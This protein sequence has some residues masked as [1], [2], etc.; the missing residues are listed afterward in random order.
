M[1]TI[2]PQLKTD[3]AG[4][5]ILMKAIAKKLDLSY[6]SLTRKLANKR[7]FNIDEV[8]KICQVL[9]IDYNYF[10]ENYIQNG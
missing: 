10:F 3:L 1:V 8:I 4:T 5:G 7:K 6:V 9:N 2:K